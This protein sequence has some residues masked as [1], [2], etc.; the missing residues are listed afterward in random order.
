[1]FPGIGLGK[2]RLLACEPKPTLCFIG[3]V[4]GEAA[5]REQG[6]DLLG[7]INRLLRLFILC[8][9]RPTRH[10]NQPN[11]KDHDQSMSRKHL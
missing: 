6:L 3:T 5:F 7:K 1:M 2:R 4:T 8:E 10:G 11:Q 9:T